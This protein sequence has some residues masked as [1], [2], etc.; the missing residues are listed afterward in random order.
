MG[1]RIFVGNLPHQVSGSELEQLFAG[2][3]T[4]RSAEVMQ[5][6]QTGRPKGFAFVEMDNDAEAQAAIQGLHE[7]EIHGRRLTV[8]EA[9]PRKYRTGGGGGDGGYGYGGGGY[10]GGRGGRGDRY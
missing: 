5:D 7:H 3:G 6:R 8:S 10:G 1:K 2:F 4:V 9:K